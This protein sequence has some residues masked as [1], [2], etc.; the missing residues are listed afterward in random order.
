MGIEVVTITA[1]SLLQIVEDKSVEADGVEVHGLQDR[2][3]GGFRD[4]EVRLSGGERRPPF[5]ESLGRS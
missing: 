5:G 3:L 2:G 1:G 4:I